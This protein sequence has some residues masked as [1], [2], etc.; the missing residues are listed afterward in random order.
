LAAFFGPALNVTAFASCQIQDKGIAVDMMAP[1]FSVGCIEY[2]E[3][4]VARVTCSL[5]AP[6]DKSLTIIGD[7][8]VIS[9]D[10]VRDEASPV[11]VKTM[12]SGGLQAGFERRVNRLRNWVQPSTVTDGW[13]IK[14]RYPPARKPSGRFVSSSKSVDFCRGPAEMAEAIREQRPCRLSAQLGL[15][16]TELIEA[17]QYPERFGGRKKIESSF[18][19]IQP[20]SWTN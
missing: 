1:D 9:T 14:R 15:H 4:V 16:V 17:L 19:P 3:G 12:P 2:A 7:D 18:D 10:N 8:G 20:L 13:Q 6:L 5:V 11:F